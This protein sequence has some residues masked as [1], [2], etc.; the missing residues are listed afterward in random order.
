MYKRNIEDL[1]RIIEELTEKKNRLKLEVEAK[2][3]CSRKLVDK[4]N[5]AINGMVI[6]LH[7]V[8]SLEHEHIHRI[9]NKKLLKN[10]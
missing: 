7:E 6:L 9:K 8:R 3:Q 1:K 2:G 5:A 4:Y 10:S